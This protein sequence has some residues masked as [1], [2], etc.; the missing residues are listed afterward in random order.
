M[1]FF[2][3]LPMFI[4]MFL[5][6]LTGG[7]IGS[8]FMGMDILLLTA[9]GRRTGKIRRVVLSYIMDGKNYVITASNGGS[10]INPAWFWNLKDNPQ[11]EIQ[12]KNKKIKVDA[13]VA[14]PKKRNQLW[15]RLIK[16]YPGFKAYQKK[17][18]RVIPMVILQPRR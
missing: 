10:D 1:K 6:R 13:K 8:S 7:V 16:V 14:E 11:A 9:R 17:T 3:K 12:V 4:H 5:Y 18:K 15:K 2:I